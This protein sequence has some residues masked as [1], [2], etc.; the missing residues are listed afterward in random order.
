MRKILFTLIL[1]CLLPISS[2]AAPP[3]PPL[4]AK[5]AEIKAPPPLRFVARDAAIIDLKSGNK[6]FFKGIGYSPY[7]SG[8]TPLQGAAPAA[9]GRYPERFAEH[10]R[11][12][13]QLGVNYLHVFPINM[14]A[15][16]FA[17]LDKTGLL[18]GQDMFVWAYEPDF[19]DEAFLAKTL[20]ALKK[21]IDHTYAVGRPDRL[22]LFSVGDE[23]QAK[24]IIETDRQH[25]LVTE[26]VGK[27]INVHHRT[28]TEVAL[29][30]LI[31][32]AIDYELTTYGRRHLYCHTSWTHVGPLGDRR[33]LE[34]PYE[35]VL[36]ADMGD[37]ICLNVYTYARG[38]RTSG[39]GSVTGSSYQGYLEDLARVTAKPIF[40]TQVGFSTSPYEPKPWVPGFGGHSVDKIPEMLREIWRD[41]TTAKG[42]DKF[43]GLAFF[44]LNDE[45]WKSG[46]YPNDYQQHDENDPEEWFGL[47]TVGKDGHLNAKGRLPEAVRQIFTQPVK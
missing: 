31:D 2:P 11:L 29:A 38:V 40:I 16:F 20:E 18:Y 43:C 37:L 14:P 6:M 39:P 41:L 33:D 7:L 9:D 36:S 8:E 5:T 22:V 30:R 26:Y 27:H 13:R 21:V 12:F 3:L 25:P 4:P 15:A 1:A 32:G 24:S 17:E 35:N 47:Y 46:D 10:F 44:E 23:L 19:L 45:W 34:V 42:H 28:P